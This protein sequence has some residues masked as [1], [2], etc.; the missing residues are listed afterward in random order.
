MVPA[1]PNNQDDSTQA[2]EQELRLARKFS[3]AD[4]IGQEAGNFMK[5]ESPVPRMVQIKTELTTLLKES[6]PDASGALQV[7]LQ[8][9][10]IADDSLISRH[11]PAPVGA[12][13]EALGA[14]LKSPDTLYELVR[15]ADAQWGEMYDERPYFQQPGQA[16]HPDDEYTHDSVRQALVD[17]LN[18][19]SADHAP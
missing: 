4:V 6:L 7:V 9:W 14:I 5:G 19:L 11:I 16:A 8:R 17:C 18:T 15:Q 2:L 10:V 12:L 13:T 3:L 1:D